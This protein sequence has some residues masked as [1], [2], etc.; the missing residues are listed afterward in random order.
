MFFYL[1]FQFPVY[2]VT[3][4][5][6]CE[7]QQNDKIDGKIK[8]VNSIYADKNFAE[9]PLEIHPKSYNNKSYIPEESVD[10][11]S[12]NSKNENSNND[13]YG[14]ILYDKIFTDEQTNSD[15][16]N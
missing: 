10:T 3:E 4:K 15:D 7:I 16:P 13:N 8:L 11:A 5:I 2:I 1:C 6:I 14:D 9:G 12:I